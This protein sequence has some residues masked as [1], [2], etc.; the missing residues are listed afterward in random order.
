MSA[1]ETTAA[2]VTTTTVETPTVETAAI[3]TPAIEAPPIKAAWSNPARAISG[4]PIS[5]RDIRDDRRG[6]HEGA[7][8]RAHP[9]SN[10]NHH[11]RCSKCGASSQKYKSEQFQFHGSF[12]L[13]L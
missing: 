7:V 5:R 12:L 9:D 13:T 3:V 11:A 2:V 1:V 10:S 6:S 4:S 8:S